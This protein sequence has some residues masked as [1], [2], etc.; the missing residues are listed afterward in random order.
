M[1]DGG[2]NNLNYDYLGFYRAYENVRDDRLYIMDTMLNIARNEIV[3]KESGTEFQKNI[4][5]ASCYLEFAIDRL[6]DM[7]CEEIKD[8][9]YHNALFEYLKVKNEH[10]GDEVLQHMKNSDRR[11]IEDI[12]Q[13][14][15]DYSSELL[16]EFGEIRQEQ[17]DTMKVSM[18]SG[19]GI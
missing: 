15:Q 8:Q 5:S 18:L 16:K 12:M 9:K 17:K 2:Y 10:P 14:Y 3:K 11:V 7:G 13:K 1:Q 19:R 6:E 4:S